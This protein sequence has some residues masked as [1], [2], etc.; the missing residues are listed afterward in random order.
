MSADGPASPRVEPSLAGRRCLVTGGSRG[1]GRAICTA[2]RAAGARVAFTYLRAEADAV[3]LLA[4]LGPE[5]RAF[6]GSVADPAH[7][8]ATVSALVAE[9]G[10]IDLLVNNAGINQVLPVALIEAEDWDAVMNVNAKGAFLFS[11]AVLRPMIRAKG[12]HILS[13]GAFSEGRVVEAPVHYAASKAALRGM[14]EAL[15]RE[16]GRYGIQVNLLAPGLLEAGQSRGLPQHRL[17]EY[18]A[19]SPLGRLIQP[20][21]V[22][23]LVVWLASGE[24]RHIT[25][26]RIAADGGI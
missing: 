15:A 3:E 26:A 9:W 19:Q 6:R 8:S 21:E 17:E 11:R 23:A 24:N 25:G 14:T 1:L 10:G 22:A 13:I 18:L 2:L 5:A 4:E 16:V 7:V 20:A 12:G